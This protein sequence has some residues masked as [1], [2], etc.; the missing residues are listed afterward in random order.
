MESGIFFSRVENSFAGVL[1][2]I[3]GHEGRCG[4]DFLF[5]FYTSEMLC[6]EKMVVR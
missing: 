4:G 6:R 1:E 2:N 5:F 3:R